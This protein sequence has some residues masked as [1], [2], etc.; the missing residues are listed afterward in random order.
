MNLKLLK[1]LLAAMKEYPFIYDKT[2]CNY[3]NIKSK[4]FYIDA[5]CSISAK[6]IEKEPK[7][8]YITGYKNYK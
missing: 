7:Y 4:Q 5:F 2:A 6:I 3:K 1:L 8:F